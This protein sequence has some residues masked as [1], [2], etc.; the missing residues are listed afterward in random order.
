MRT[1]ILDLQTFQS[2]ILY[3]S[4]HTT[5]FTF[6]S[7]FNLSSNRCD[8]FHILYISFEVS[9]SME[10]SCKKNWSFWSKPWNRIQWK[11]DWGFQ[12]RQFNLHLLWFFDKKS[13]AT[14]LLTLWLRLMLI[15]FPKNH[16]DVQLQRLNKL[17]AWW[18]SLMYLSLIFSLCGRPQTSKT[19][20]WD[21][22]NLRQKI[23]ETKWVCW[24]AHT[25]LRAEFLP[26]IHRVQRTAQGPVEARWEFRNSRIRDFAWDDTSRFCPALP[27]RRGNCD[28]E[29]LKRFWSYLGEAA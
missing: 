15:F 20:F 13:A 27:R 18:P 9:C 24:R 17:S 29:R 28:L 8:I 2:K 6:F 10:T 22:E 3:C 7:I 11:F 19:I 21:G 26:Q 4:E 5:I 23:K 12:C 1:L 14:M 16:Q 25:T